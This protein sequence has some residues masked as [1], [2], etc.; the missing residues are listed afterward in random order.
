[1]EGPKARPQSAYTQRVNTSLEEVSDWLTKLLLGIGLVQLGKVPGLLRS[2]S[3][4]INADSGALPNSEGFGIA[5]IV[6]FRLN[7]NK[8]TKS[9]IRNCAGRAC[10]GQI[11]FVLF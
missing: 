4:V 2:Y 11:Q 5:I 10:L 3:K 1:M 9:D 8:G 6:Y 7:S